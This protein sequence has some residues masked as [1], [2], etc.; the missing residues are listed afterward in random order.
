MEEQRLVNAYGKE[1]I[2]AKKQDRLRIIYARVLT[3]IHRPSS[4]HNDQHIHCWTL[5]LNRG[6]HSSVAV[7]AIWVELRFH[8]RGKEYRSFYVPQRYRLI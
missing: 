5:G 1:R 4:I 6:R 2:G 8:F 3:G 7:A